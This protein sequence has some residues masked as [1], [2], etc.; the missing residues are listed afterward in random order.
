MRGLHGMKGQAMSTLAKV[1]LLVAGLVLLLFFMRE[2]MFKGE[3][4]GDELACRESIQQHSLIVSTGTDHLPNIACEPRSITIDNTQDSA[5]EEIV[6]EIAHCWDRWGWQRA[7]PWVSPRVL[8]CGRHKTQK[9]RGRSA[10][11][12]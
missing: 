1:L 8:G 3:E 12:G 2:F 9:D 6:R 11:W 4:A 5:K 7:P 10:Q